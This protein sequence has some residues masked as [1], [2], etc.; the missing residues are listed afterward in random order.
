MPLSKKQETELVTR[1][2]LYFQSTLDHPSWKDW[3]TNIAPTCYR[4]R[5]GEQWSK[6]ELA[7]LKKRH[8][9]PIQNNQVSVTINRLVGQ[10][11]RQKYRIRY[12]G[13]NAGTDQL[14]AET[15]SDIMLFIR[16]QNGLEFEER[17]QVDEGFTS[18]FGVLEVGVEWNDL[19]ESEISISCE[20]ELDF[21][22]DPES[23]RYDWNE[24]A[25]F[26]A[27]VKW[28]AIDEAAELYPKH[29]KALEALTG[30]ADAGTQ[31][32]TAEADDL[33]FRNFVDVKNRR[34]LLIEIEWK[35]F[36]KV[37][38]VLVSTPQGPQVFDADTMTR[39]DWTALEA[40]GYEYRQADRVETKLHSAV[41]TRAILLEHKDLERK[42][43][44]WVPFFMYRRKNGS[45]YSLI[46]LGLS[47]QD[48]INKRESKSTHL[49]NNNRVL[50][51]KNNIEDKTQF[52]EEMAKPDGIAEV[53]SIEKI[54]VDDHKDLGQIFYAMHLGGMK[55]FRSIVGVN[56][57]A[58][59]EPS[60]MRSGVGVKAKVAM[61][62]LVVAPVFD[63]TRRTRVCLAK[64]VL[65]FVQLYYTEGKIFSITD[66]LKKTRSV[67]LDAAQIGAIKQGIYDIVEEDAPDI[68]S[69]RQEQWALLMQY[70]PQMVQLGPF[71]QKVMLRLSDLREKDDLIKEMESTQKPPPDLPRITV[72]AKL[73]ELTAPE[74]G[75][76]WEIMGRPD[77]GQGI[78]QSG[79]PPAS[80]VEIQAEQAR[81]QGKM[82]ADQMKALG[83][84]MKTRGDMAKMQME[85]EAKRLEVGGKKQLMALDIA[86]KRL[87]VAKAGIDARNAA[88]KPR[89]D[90]D[91]SSSD[92]R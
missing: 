19:W 86:K 67:N 47:M 16:Q 49:L 3:R 69:V 13:R 63:N 53:R 79:I 65:E 77:I 75:A 46:W 37:N 15:L 2:E 12:Q 34:V 73:E 76:M 52:A 35:T 30:D 62:D 14:G 48:A 74:R 92:S 22:P 28:T 41:F 5:E 25:N 38:K 4:Y 10:F 45:P 64:T 61:T 57:E 85:M 70:I 36:E 29:K 89:G 90:G 81:E 84:T 91:G 7:T 20:D 80:L 9:P 68:T 1:L 11:V 50:T 82:Q 6:S 42:R 26:I 8:Q 83:A 51:E 56:P 17:D 78:A 40:S 54:K 71:W 59:G 39:A 58:L 21:F 32:E 66:D 18:G 27:R 23:R 24:D 72:T 43:Y 31:G 88:N 33:R 44:K 87:E 55:D 60:E